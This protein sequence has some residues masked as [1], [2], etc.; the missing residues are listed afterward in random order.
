MSYAV[1]HPD[2]AKRVRSPSVSVAVNAF[3]RDSEDQEE[4]SV[5]A[6]FVWAQSLDF[7]KFVAGLCEGEPHSAAR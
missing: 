5:L 4:L 6:P 7:S 3:P 1:L 2:E